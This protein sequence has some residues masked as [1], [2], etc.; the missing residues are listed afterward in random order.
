MSWVNF[1][2]WL[3]PGSWVGGWGSLRVHWSSCGLVLVLTT[4]LTIIG[5]PPSTVDPANCHSGNTTRIQIQQIQFWQRLTTLSRVNLAN[6]QCG[7]NI[8]MLYVLSHSPILINW[9]W[10][11]MKKFE[12]LQII[13]QESTKFCPLQLQIVSKIGKVWKGRLIWQPPF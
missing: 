2:S 9:L 11:F 5:P 1:A 6:S 12:T 7:H 4:L 13:G 8:E 10:I 3:D